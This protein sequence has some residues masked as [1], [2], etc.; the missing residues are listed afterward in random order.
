MDKLK[1][2]SYALLMAYDLHKIIEQNTDPLKEYIKSASDTYKEQILIYLN[3]IGTTP[4]DIYS[5]TP[6]W[7]EL[8]RNL[9]LMVKPFC[10]I[11]FIESNNMFL[12][13]NKWHIEP[14]NIDLKTLSDRIVFIITKYI[15]LKRLFHIIYNNYKDL[16]KYHSDIEIGSEQ[17][18]EIILKKINKGGLPLTSERAK[19]EI[20]EQFI[21]AKK[22]KTATFEFVLNNLP[23]DLLNK[24]KTANDNKISVF[25]QRELAKE[26][27]VYLN[28][29]NMPVTLKQYILGFSFMMS[30][31]IYDK[32]EFIRRKRAKDKYYEFSPSDYDEYLRTKGYNI[33]KSL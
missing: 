5:W 27:L 3:E 15:H 7:D 12:L 8:C 21:E 24:I 23:L 26:M 17:F 20:R 28:L 32:D 18:N 9:N 31:F 4:I 22:N 29:T 2:K 10:R 19:R 11:S 13:L 6:D 14:E 25:F 33:Y 30:L 16:K 1:L